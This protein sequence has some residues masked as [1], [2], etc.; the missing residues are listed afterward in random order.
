MSSLVGDNDT[1]DTYTIHTYKQ[2]VKHIILTT[3]YVVRQSNVNLE[4]HVRCICSDGKI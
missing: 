1:H 3:M 2:K 4:D